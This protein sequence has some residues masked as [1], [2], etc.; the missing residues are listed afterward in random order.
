MTMID[1]INSNG[2]DGQVPIIAIPNHPDGA[3]PVTAPGFDFWG[4][5]V[6]SALVFW[7]CIAH[8]HFFTQRPIVSSGD[9]ACFDQY[10][11]CS[12]IDCLP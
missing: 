11:L 8:F 7:A 10:P 12:P 9:P 5:P 3:T 2:R 6:E 4:F 1:P